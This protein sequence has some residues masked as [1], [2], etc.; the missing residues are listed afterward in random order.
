MKRGYGIGKLNAVNEK[1]SA[2]IELLQ[3]THQKLNID[4][5]E[6]ETLPDRLIKF[7]GTNLFPI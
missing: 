6:V 1:Q 7:A 5:T 4:T 3:K 2:Y